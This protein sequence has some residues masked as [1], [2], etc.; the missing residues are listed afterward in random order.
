MPI[1]Y[2]T[3]MSAA[4]ALSN[5]AAFAG[6]VKPYMDNE[7]GQ[8]YYNERE[9]RYVIPY[10]RNYD[11]SVP[12]FFK[13]DDKLMPTGQHVYAEIDMSKLEY[14][15]KN[16][17]DR[18]MLKF[19]PN[20]IKYIIV[21]DDSDIHDTI[22]YLRTLPTVYDEIAIEKLMTKLITCQQIKEDF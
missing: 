2:N 7:T 9:W 22:N 16:I 1:E 4:N 11:G 10:T 5:S 15:K 18:Y 19:E 17:A 3:L 21:Q 12:F 6:S 20:D 14:Y 8:L 13:K